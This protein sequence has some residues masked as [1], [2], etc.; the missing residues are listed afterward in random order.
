MLY[1][2]AVARNIGGHLRLSPWPGHGTRVDLRLPL[3]A[4]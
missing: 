4:H 2:R 1:C 3:A